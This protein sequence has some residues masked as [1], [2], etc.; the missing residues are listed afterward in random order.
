MS[1]YYSFHLSKSSKCFLHHCPFYKQLGL[2]VYC[3]SVQYCTIKGT[4][5]MDGIIT[6][7]KLPTATCWLQRH[8]QWQWEEIWSEREKGVTSAFVRFF[9]AALRPNW[10][11]CWSGVLQHLHGPSS[12]QVTNKGTQYNNLF[13]YNQ[14]H[15]EVSWQCIYSK[16]CFLHTLPCCPQAGFSY[17][18]YSVC[19]AAV[20]IHMICSY[21]PLPAAIH[22]FHS[23][24]WEWKSN[25]QFTS[26]QR[27][28]TEGK[29]T[30]TM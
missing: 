15:K 5:T 20:G 23:D 6:L 8:R 7:G 18:Q 13:I 11:S 24:T 28:W 22:D 30:G 1:R 10:H 16:L 12:K 26:K 27:M 14:S 2:C 21:W 3:T 4:E 17:I 25:S 19:A 9:G 29:E